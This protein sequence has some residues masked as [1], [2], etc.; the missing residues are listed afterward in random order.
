MVFCDEGEWTGGAGVVGIGRWVWWSICGRVF[1]WIIG[2]VY[3][4][5]V[6]LLGRNEIFAM[7]IVLVESV[8][9]TVMAGNCLVDS[10][11]A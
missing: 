11:V 9:V 6:S 8:K 10:T 5:L 4:Q 7:R 3:I 1:L 2:V